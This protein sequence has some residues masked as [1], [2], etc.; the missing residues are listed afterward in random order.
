M[1][2]VVFLII[3]GILGRVQNQMRGEGQVDPVSRAV[4][5]AVGFT[6]QPVDRSLDWISEF[7]A[8]IAQASQ[9]KAENRALRDRAAAADLYAEREAALQEQIDSLRRLANLP[10]Y[11]GKTKIPALV[12][13]FFPYENRMT[14]NVGIEKGIK[15]GMPVLVGE[16]LLGVISTSIRGSSQL[17]LVFSSQVKIGASV[18]KPGADPQPGLLKGVGTDRMV[19]EYLESTDRVQTFDL[20]MTSG[21]SERIPRGIPIGR[22]LEVQQEIDYGQKKVTVAPFAKAGRA[23]EVVVLR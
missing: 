16:G 15:P 9:F 13:G 10:G 8:G 23:K 21:Y 2:L 14:L 7:A 18:I 1:W 11:L 20:V 3:G 12:V 5:T 4:Q 22:V 17:N 19:F 6:S